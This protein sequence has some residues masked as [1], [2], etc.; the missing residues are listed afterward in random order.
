MFLLTCGMHL[1]S[2][3]SRYTIQ[4]VGGGDDDDDDDDDDG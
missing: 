1:R 3:C 4:M 2:H